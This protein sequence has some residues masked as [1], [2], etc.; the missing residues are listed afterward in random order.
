MKYVI[1]ASLLLLK[2]SLAA[3]TQKGAQPANQPTNPPVNQTRAIVVGISDYQSN[4][5]PDLQFAH[6]DAVAFAAWLKSPAGGNVPEDNITLQINDKAT[7]AAVGTALYS[8]LDVCKPGDR[9]IFYFSGHGDVETKTR[10]QPGYLLTW[11]S[12]ANVYMVGALNLRDLQEIVSTLSDNQVRVLLVTDACH[13]GK[14]AGTGVGGTQAT[15]QALVQQFANEVKIMSC[16]PNEFSLEGPQ[17][18]DGRGVFSWHLLDG[19]TGLADQ[20]SDGMINLFEIQRY[21]Q[22]QVPRETAP[23]SQIPFAVGNLQTPLNPVNGPSLAALKTVKAGA[24]ADISKTGSK[25]LEDEVLARADAQTREQYRAF[26]AAMQQGALLEPA[27][28]KPCANELYLWL[29][30]NDQLAPLHNLMTRDF[31]VALLD[32]VQQAINALLA[33]DPYEANNYKFNPGKYAMYPVYLQRSLE[34]LGEKHYMYRSILSKKYFFEGYNLARSL[35]QS[36][37]QPA[38]RDSLKEVA[39]SN[40]LEALRLQPESAYLYHAIGALYANNLPIHTDSLVLWCSRAIEQAPGWVMP[41]LDIFYEYKHIQM[42]ISRA[43]QWM[44]RALNVKSDNY[45]VQEQ[46]SWFRQAQGRTDD[47]IAICREMIKEKP[48]LFNAYNTLAFTHYHMTGDYREAER[49]FELARARNVPVNYLLEILPLIYI[50]TRRCKQSI[51]LLKNG[52]EKTNPTP[53]IRGVVI[54]YLME[55]YI[56]LGDFE[57]PERWAK[58][59]FDEKW[60]A[61]N[62]QVMVKT[63]LGRV[64][65]LQ[66]R[67]D[68]A[69][70]FF[71]DALRT[72]PAPDPC[73]ITDYAL[74]GEAARMQHQPGKAA[75]FY[76]QALAYTSNNIWL[77]MPVKEEACFL[78]GRFLLG[79]NRPAEAADCFQK[80]MDMRKYGPW[81]EFGFALLSARKGKQQEALDWLER[82]LVN[83]YPDSGSILAEPLFAKL[84][85]TKR[86]RALMTKHF[87]KS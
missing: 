18:G 67:P 13:A 46:L 25:G 53:E 76:Q 36:E 73:F 20:N 80:S 38:L 32:D 2:L 71:H 70:A 83:F 84:R 49:N 21:L 63:N 19:L 48:D 41:M 17:W 78:Y 82:S 39:K 5:I 14:L 75:A 52:L 34:L 79:Q 26:K 72:D 65:L 30:E 60:G 74:L 57:A 23:H 77:D 81:G 27:D 62:D 4:D 15:A 47:V 12:P 43:E 56:L 11:D 54:A 16:Q 29:I 51:D 50:R 87:P 44:Q 61:A 42:D 55:A 31:A 86:F 69:A 85:K 35:V 9:F 28:G 45:F 33:N 3:Q 24:I 58:K 10:N 68:E 8:M 37:A 40:Y 7:N 66:H 1:L 22:E 59:F 6:L 64:R